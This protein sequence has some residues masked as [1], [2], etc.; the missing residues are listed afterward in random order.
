ML[1]VSVGTAKYIDLKEPKNNHEQK[2]GIENMILKN[3][4]RSTD[5]AGLAVLIALR[6]GNF[7]RPH[8][9]RHQA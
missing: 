2:I 7:L 1:I 8:W 5:L 6:G 3:V 9:S 4:K